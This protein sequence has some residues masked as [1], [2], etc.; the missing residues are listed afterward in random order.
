MAPN[1]WRGL[2]WAASRILI[3]FRSTLHS[4]PNLSQEDRAQLASEGDAVVSLDAQLAVQ[5]NE[6]PTMSV[7]FSCRIEEFI[8]Y[9]LFIG[10]AE[11][12]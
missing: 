1:E 3:K 5:R 9:C 4:D 8:D 10:S 11:L 7:P 2:L 6:P 12:N